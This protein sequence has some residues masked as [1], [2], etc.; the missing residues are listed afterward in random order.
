MTLSKEKI[1]TLLEIKTQEYNRP[2]FIEADPISIPHLF[3]KKQDIEIAGFFSATL[4]WGQRKTILLK[5]REL[6]AYM[7]FSPFEFIKNHKE[8][9]LLPFLNFKHR[10][11]N[12]TDA[13]YFIHFL[14][15]LYQRHESMEEVLVKGMGK[16]ASNVESGLNYFKNMFMSGESLPARTGKHVASP[17]KKSACKR[18]NMFLRWMVRKDNNGV[19][20]GIWE[21]L[22]PSQLVCPCDLHVER[23]SRKLGLITRKQVDWQTALELT[24]NLKLMDPADPAK[25]DFA[26]FGLGVFEKNEWH[27]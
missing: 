4:A 22:Q 9:D 11:F 14:R 6:L 17:E 24:Y 19:D 7:D 23:V 10:T 15:N 25:Y 20:F 18:L 2:E 3:S 5:C 27:F 1:R 26:L 12:A 8:K 16:N 13:L 21:K